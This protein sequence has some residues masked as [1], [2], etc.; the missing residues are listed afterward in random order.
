MSETVQDRIKSRSDAAFA[1]E[2]RQGT[3]LAAQVRTVALAVVLFWQA[4]DSP[5]TGA[6]Y[7][8]NLLEIFVFV[9]LGGLQFFA[10]FSRRGGIGAQYAFVTVDCL[11]LALGL[12]WAWFHSTCGFLIRMRVLQL[13]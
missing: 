5:E 4:I 6:S 9:L 11:L 8:F 13:Q 1:E 3:M 10:A 12:K 7:Y 2:E